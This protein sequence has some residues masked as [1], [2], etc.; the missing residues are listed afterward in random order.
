[1]LVTVKLFHCEKNTE[2][3][4]IQKLCNAKLLNIIMP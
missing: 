3:G 4:I 2:L 1:M